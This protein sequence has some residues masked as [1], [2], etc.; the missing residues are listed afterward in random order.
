M[1]LRPDNPQ[2]ALNAATALIGQ[3]AGRRKRMG[4]VMRR[5]EAHH[6]AFPDYAPAYTAHISAYR[7]TRELEEADRPFR[8]L[9]R[10]VSERY[11][12]MAGARRHSGGPEAFRRR[13]ARD[14]RIA[15]T[16]ARGARY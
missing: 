11:E 1:K 15:R 2:Y 5:L 8:H 3:P 16:P 4:E 14:C 10:K 9:V 7:E 13:G 6:E 12:T